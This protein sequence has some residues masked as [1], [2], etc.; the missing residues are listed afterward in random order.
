MKGSRGVSVL[1]GEVMLIAI[2]IGA[3]TM[4]AIRV[5]GSVGPP[6]RYLELAV[7]VENAEPVPAD[8]LRV[9]LYHLGGDSLDIP[10]GEDDEFWVAVGRLYPP[11]VWQAKVPW[12]SW[13]FSDPSDGFEVGENAVGYVYYSGASVNIGDRIWVDV[14]DLD[15]EK[16]I[17]H[18][19]VSV[20][21]G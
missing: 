13:V 6:P 14:F 8:N 7:V 11:P 4:L 21:S 2:I 16:L 18:T 9:I 20:Q 1:I 17:F 12:N 3:L 15:A 19:V 5:I 10:R